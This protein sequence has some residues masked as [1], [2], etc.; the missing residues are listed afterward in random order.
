MIKRVA[1]HFIGL[2]GLYGTA[3]DI[4]QIIP[5][6]PEATSLA[7]FAEVP[8]SHYTGVPN[9]SI[10]IYTIQQN[11]IS[12]PISL[13]YHSRGV[14]VGEIAP[15]VGLGWALQY[16]GSISRQI[17]GGADE[18][19]RGYLNN[20]Y[21]MSF[22]TDATKRDLVYDTYV[23]YP[24]Y[25]FT[26][27][28]FHFGANGTGG[29]FMIDKADDQVLVQEFDDITI[30]PHNINGTNGIERF[31]IIDKNGHTFYFG[32]SKDGSR[33]ARNYDEQLESISK[34]MN[35]GIQILGGSQ[36]RFYN[37]WQ[38]MDIETVYGDLIEFHYSSPQGEM[39]Q[40]YRHSY[41]RIENNVPT[42]HASKLR[43]FQ[44]QLSEIR[45]KTGKLVFESAQAERE[46]LAGSHSL[47]RI[48]IYDL[49]D[50]LIKA[51]DFGYEY[52]VGSNTNVNSYLLASEPR[53]NKRLFLKSIRETAP[54]QSQL[55]PYLFDYNVEKLPNRFSTAQDL[56]G[57][58]NG[59]DNGEYLT[60]FDYGTTNV[61][62]TVNTQKA[63]AGMLKKITYPTQG[64]VILE[65]EHNKGL[66]PPEFQNLFFQNVNP[67]VPKA[68]GL[69]HLNFFDPNIYDGSTYTIQVD[70]GDGLMG[71]VKASLRFD[72]P[73]RAGEFS[74]YMGTYT[75]QQGQNIS[76]P[77][78]QPGTYNLVVDPPNNHDPIADPGQGFQITLS[79]EE[80]REDPGNGTGGDQ[81]IVYA[82]GKRIHKMRYFDANGHIRV[83]E[84]EYL[85]DMGQSSGR[86]FGLPNFYPISANFGDIAVLEAYGAVPGSPLGTPQGNSIGY[87]KVIEYDGEKNINNG[88]TELEFTVIPD[89]GDYYKLPYPLPTDNEWLRGKVLE[90]QVFRKNQGGGYSVL[91]KTENTYLFGD[92][93]FNYQLPPPIFNPQGFASQCNNNAV[94]GYSKDARR[95]HLPL[96]QFVEP[97]G[98]SCSGGNLAYNTYYLTG[99]TLD[100]GRT[101]VTD[102]PDSGD[103]VITTTDYSYD[104]DHHYQLGETKTKD[105]QGITMVNKMYYPS[106]VNH[107]GLL[108]RHRLAQVVRQ[109]V[110]EDK[111]AD[112]QLQNNE[113]I[114]A[115]ETQFKL[116]NNDFYLL[117][118]EFVKAQKG[119]GPFEDRV[120]YMGYDNDGNPLELAKVGD[121]STSYLWGHNKSLPIAKIEN[122]DYEAI[123]MALGLAD[124][125]AVMALDETDMATI[126]G[127]RQSLPQAL[128]TTYT[129]DLLVGMTGSTDPRGYTMDYQYD[130]FN[131]LISV[132][133]AQGNLVQDYQYHYRGQ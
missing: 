113:L 49:D 29:K 133:D 114:S 90:S 125:S 47:E 115:Q 35:G 59:A 27:D 105:S 95:Y 13:N 26:P 122:A 36:D 89:A 129:Y 68:E 117:L 12:I 101:V 82:G 61:D 107:T 21:D 80:E 45:F 5:P 93:L 3:Q 58:Y 132:T 94:S 34:P 75:F 7:K 69:A 50:Q 16:G 43:M 102:Y 31:T 33:S 8:V 124:A 28:L 126:D 9:V 11:G 86:I 120:A 96:I 118:P 20:G 66:E 128:I 108:D 88:K 23:F 38:L 64:G 130:G 55:P 65:Y 46:D 14:K 1:F 53:A 111:N 18:D 131:R 119:A 74:V 60:F 57:Y 41:D 24:D 62:R 44:F 70:I 39:S 37:S 15:R 4:P 10:P 56:W 92:V 99:G 91:K 81:E 42:H 123:R 109:E 98:S 54:D 97:D 17:R 48:G 104:Y 106:N 78:I 2:M 83:K 73:T 25:D 77:G 87:A 110:Y 52:T 67:V 19:T 85:D 116:W 71:S 103:Q 30:T 79:W 32:V 63:E 127:L 51:F 121:R 84:Y 112:D 72:D 6:S 40:T 22:F 76:Y 100:L